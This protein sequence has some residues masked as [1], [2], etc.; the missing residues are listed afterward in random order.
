MKNID[1]NPPA[2]KP[3]KSNSQSAKIKETG[4]EKIKDR[5]EIK[6]AGARI[7][8]DNNKK[9]SPR[10]KPGNT[11]KI[12]AKEKSNGPEIMEDGINST[13]ARTKPHD[14]PPHEQNP[15]DSQ[16]K[17][18]PIVGMGASAGGL[19]SFEEFFRSLKPS[20]GVAFVLVSHLDPSHASM[21]TEILQRCTEMPVQEVRNNMTVE[22]N[23]V[24]VIPPNYDMAI[25]HGELQLVIPGK[26]RGQRMPIDYFLRSLAEDQ[27]EQAIG[28]ILSGTGTDGTF[29][30]RAILGAGGT[31]F[32]QDPS[33]AKYDGMPSSAVRNNLATYV[34]AVD[35]IPEKLLSCVENRFRKETGMSSSLTDPTIYDTRE[36]LKIVRS[37]TTHDFSLYKQT[38]VGR[39]IERRMEANN[40]ES[41]DTYARFLKENPEETQIL[42]KELLINVTNFFRDSDAFE[43][44]K[45]DIFPQMFLDKPE[46]YCFRIWVPAS[47]S[48]EE[49]YSIAICLMEYMDEVQ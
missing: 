21:L 8:P 32:V 27:E 43:I 11:K 34:L 9:V 1:N 6:T 17:F 44:L 29:G 10:S 46:D 26:I 31:T 3:V 47:S 42:F 24:Y 22:P 13:S 36:I 28:I 39:R 2:S 18:F 45:K 7:E 48:G 5:A 30:L 35:K 41:I 14:G 33:T 38:T 15:E 19:E 4:P 16:K 40:V 37:A 20:S 23:H 25:F 12:T 49:A